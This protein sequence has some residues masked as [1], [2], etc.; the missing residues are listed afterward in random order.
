M[1]SRILQG[2][3][4]GVE[5]EW[6]RERGRLIQEARRDLEAKSWTNTKATGT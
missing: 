6:S 5:D 1:R 2:H 3:T 4:G